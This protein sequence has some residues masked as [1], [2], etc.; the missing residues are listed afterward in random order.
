MPVTEMHKQPAA[1]N[2]SSVGTTANSFVTLE[3]RPLIDFS[4]KYHSYR[5]YLLINILRDTKEIIKSEQWGW[6]AKNNS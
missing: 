3:R 6:C 1:P 4:T 5:T 2:I